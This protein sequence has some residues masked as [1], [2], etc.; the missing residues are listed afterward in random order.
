MLFFAVLT[1]SSVG[2]CIHSFLN[3]HDFTGSLHTFFMCTAGQSWN[4]NVICLSLSLSTTLASYNV[5]C[6]GIMNKVGRGYT[7]LFCFFIYFTGEDI[8][9]EIPNFSPHILQYR[10]KGNDKYI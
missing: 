6:L 8:T 9:R 7:R 2:G 1:S 3:M 5:V 4:T 10:K